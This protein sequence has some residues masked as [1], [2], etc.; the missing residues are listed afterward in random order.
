MPY[1][2]PEK[3]R[4]CQRRWRENMTSEQLEKRRERIRIYVWTHKL[5]IVCDDW[6][7]L[8]DYYKLT[9]HCEYCNIELCEG[10]TAA[11]RRCLDHDHSTGQVRGVICHVCNTRDVFNEK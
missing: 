4:E 2:D 9:N 8:H 10:R 3:R 11:N 7:E 1:K 5:K 6:E